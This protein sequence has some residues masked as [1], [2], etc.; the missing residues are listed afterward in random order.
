LQL[1]CKGSQVEKR[2]NKFGLCASNPE[3]A[4]CCLMCQSGVCA[5]SSPCQERVQ[6]QV[7]REAQQQFGM[8]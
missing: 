3:V 2:T 8:R 1:T 4:V 6:L 5:Y 7:F